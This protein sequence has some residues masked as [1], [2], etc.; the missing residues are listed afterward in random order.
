MKIFIDFDDVIF[1][2]KRFK[3]D[4]IG[5]FSKN[6]ITRQ[7]FDNSYYT[8]QKKA[9]MEGRYYDPKNQI[10]VLK[11]R[12]KID[13]KKLEKDLDVF[14]SDMKK[15]VFPDVYGFLS[16]F[17]KNDLFL[18]TY[19]HVRFQKKK[20][21]NSGINKFFRRTLVSKDNKINIVLESCR[22]YSFSP[23]REDI[24]LIDDRPEQIEKTEAI[25]KKIR[26]FRMC[27]PEGR[28][29]DLLC[30]DKDWEVKD[31]KEV[32]KIILQEKLK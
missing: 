4:L 1:N 28:Y 17:P 13:N 29:S 18:I 19:G 3:K 15:Y 8:F 26:T 24:L 30:I 32:Q 9:Q 14:L 20:I 25:R 12:F 5:V 22:K 21:R 16:N 23:E 2:A 7:E 6:G 27:R 11:K 10:K 31:L